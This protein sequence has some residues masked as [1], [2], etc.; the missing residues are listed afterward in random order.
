MF[1]NITAKAEGIIPTLISG[2][3]TGRITDITFRD[4]TVEHAGGEKDMT[5]P[6]PEN[7]KGYPENR[8]YGRENPAGGLYIRHADNILVENF[9]IRQRNTDERPP[10]FL[11]DATDIHIERLQSTGS[12]ASNKI[13]CSNKCSNITLDRKAVE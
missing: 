4:I 3:P 6:V 12:I 7:L 10:V 1:S 8:M 13:E 5:Q 11:D 2:T 9:R